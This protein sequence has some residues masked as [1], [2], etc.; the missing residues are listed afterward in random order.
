M[1]RGIRKQPRPPGRRNRGFGEPRKAWSEYKT[2]YRRIDG[3]RAHRLMVE[4]RTGIKLPATAVVHHVNENDTLTNVGPLV[5]CEDQAYH[6]LLEIR[7]RALRE[8]GNA[9]WLKCKV[10]LKYDD[11]KNLIVRER[12]SS[13]GRDR[14]GHF[15][16]SHVLYRGRCV[17]K[18]TAPPE[19]W[20]A[21]KPR[22]EGIWRG[23][24][25]YRVQCII[26]GKTIHSGTFAKSSHGKRHVR[27]GRAVT[28]VEDAPP[29]HRKP[30][31][32]RTIYQLAPEV[33][34]LFAMRRDTE[35]A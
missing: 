26:C 5:V 7:G 34:T 30:G 22:D 2:K 9:N 19:N 4:Q 20:Y 21:A 27:D 14:S 28:R 3:I 13:G 12:R 16:V 33:A 10:C 18:P 31:G 15:D 32:T 23:A 29:E 17:D 11:P 1:P 35:K 8:C 6:A 25:E 24:G